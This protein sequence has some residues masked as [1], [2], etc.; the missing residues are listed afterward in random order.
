MQENYKMIVA[1]EEQFARE[2]TLGVIVQ[3]PLSVWH[4]LIPGVFIFDFLR[5]NTAISRYTRHFMFPRRLA[6]DAAQNLL[7]GYEA[8]SVNSRIAA[9]IENWLNA[10]GLYS[11]QLARAQKKAVDLLAAHYGK[12]LAAE[13]TG[14]DELIENA[15][16][17]REAYESHLQELSTAEDDIDREI[18]AKAGDNQKLKEKLQ[19]EKQQVEMRRKKILEAIF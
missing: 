7:K 3:Q 15:Y 14:Y 5:R 4:Y 19:L 6:I 11:P 8:A 17:S 2:V 1:A 13:G 9:E 18:I 16:A 10:L 12:L